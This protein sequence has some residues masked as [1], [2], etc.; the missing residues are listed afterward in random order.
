MFGYENEMVFPIYVW[1]Q[2]FE[3]SVD[4]LLLIDGDKS[5]YMYIKDFDRF[6]FHET[7]NKN[8]KWFC[9]SCLQCFISENVLTKHKESYLCINGKPSVKLEKW[10]I[11]FENYFKQTPVSF[12][13]Y[14]DFECNLRDIESYE[15]F[16]AK[17][18]QNHIPCSFAYKTICVDNRFTKQIVV[19]RGENAAYEFI[20]AI[21]KEYKYCRK[22]MNKHFN[23]NLIWVK[24]KNIYFNKVTVVGFVKN[25]LIM[26]KKK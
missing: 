12:K 10:I 15:G 7:K 18:Y 6:I 23:K 8:K 16:Y 14:A 11:E 22:V 4:L 9:R 2:K 5:H 25:L 24:E 13:F 19:Y 21:L 17:K 20:K 3:D 26:M 1:D